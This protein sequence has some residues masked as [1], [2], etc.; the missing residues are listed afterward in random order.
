MLVDTRA[1]PDKMDPK[2]VRRWLLCWPSAI[3]ISSSFRR[4]FFFSVHKFR[5]QPRRTAH[6]GQ[7]GLVG[8]ALT[9]AD[10]GSL[11]RRQQHRVQDTTS[12]ANW[13]ENPLDGSHWQFKPSD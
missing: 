2:I 12:P 6:G 8:A 7:F 4:R 11:S 10:N 3:R 1:I 9:H 5:S 13:A